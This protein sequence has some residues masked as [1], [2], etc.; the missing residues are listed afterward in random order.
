MEKIKNKNTRLIGRKINKLYF[1]KINKK[2][3]IFFKS[4]SI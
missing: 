2:N 1:R 4:T 3:I